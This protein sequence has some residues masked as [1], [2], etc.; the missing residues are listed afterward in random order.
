MFVSI[1]VFE[2]IC[3]PSPTG[4]SKRGVKLTHMSMVQQEKLQAAFK[5]GM[6]KVVTTEA[7]LMLTAELRRFFTFITVITL[8]PVSQQKAE[9]KIEFLS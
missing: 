2:K 7:V 6:R 9:N 8:M 5:R 3:S 4:C 1:S